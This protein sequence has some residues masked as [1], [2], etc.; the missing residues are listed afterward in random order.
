MMA[1]SSFLGEMFVPTH[2]V[3]KHAAMAS[4]VK[5]GTPRGGRQPVAATASHSSQPYL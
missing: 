5:D 2:A 3:T 4:V 1:V